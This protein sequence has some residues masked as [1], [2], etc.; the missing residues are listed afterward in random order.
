MWRNSP[1]VSRNRYFDLYNSYSSGALQPDFW[2]LSGSGASMARSTSQ[3][4]KT[5]YT[6]AVT[7]SGTNAVVT[8]DVG[9]QETGVSSDSLRGEKVTAV[10]VG[11]S[12][13]ASSLTVKVD[14]GVDTTTS[15]AHSGDSTFEELTAE[16]TVSDSA[17][18]L[19][20]V[21]TVAVDETVYLGE[22]YL[23]VGSIYDS[24]RRDSFEEWRV[25]ERGYEQGASFPVILP[26]RGRGGHYLVTSQRSYPSFTDSRIQAGTADSDE[27]DAPIEIVATGAIGRLYEKVAQR[28][29]ENTQREAAIATEWNRRFEG[30]ARRH[31][32]R[33]G[34]EHGAA[35]TFGRKWTQG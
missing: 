29:N 35:P 30:M 9:L 2:T 18:K 26:Q 11:Y 1:Q 5:K 33:W 22:C 25:Y 28:D 19:D 12:A 17:T 32:F 10:L 7:R 13:N 6:L 16:H 21:V 4:W 8:Q 31:L 23:V 24:A 14:D 20:I 27:T 3:K 34:T 15:S